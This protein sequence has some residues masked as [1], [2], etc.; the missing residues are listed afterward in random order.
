[1]LFITYTIIIVL[2]LILVILKLVKIY[3]SFMISLDFNVLVFFYLYLV[4]NGIPI[5]F[6]NESIL[7]YLCKHKFNLKLNANDLMNIFTDNID[8]KYNDKLEAI[9][10]NEDNVINKLILMFRKLPL[11][12]ANEDN[13]FIDNFFLSI[14]N[15]DDTDKLMIIDFKTNLKADF[16][17]YLII[18][19]SILNLLLL[20][21]YF[22][23]VIF[24]IYIIINI[25]VIINILKKS[26]IKTIE[27]CI[28]L[29]NW[30]ANLVAPLLILI[31][32][33]EQFTYNIYITFELIF[34]LI[35][36]LMGFVILSKDLVYSK[37]SKNNNFI[38]Y[39]DKIYVNILNNYRIVFF[40]S[41]FIMLILSNIYAFA[42]MLYQNNQAELLFNEFLLNSAMNY[43]T[44]TNDLLYLGNYYQNR[45]IFLYESIISFVNN[46][47]L[48]S[49]MA[50][51]FMKTYRIKQKKS[52]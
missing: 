9:L 40:F 19:I 25:L 50:Q 30:I 29:L 48:L 41:L 20:F 5:N 17:N 14:F 12:K 10:V 44:N 39:L 51:Y 23:V 34:L 45:L 46:T 47:L 8:E 52:D 27:H 7:I 1:M 3:K 13:T 22:N 37:Y 18:I 35:I 6:V 31:I 28:Y 36:S 16:E 33:G 21:I 2:V 42:I 24:T 38:M 11:K 32:Y 26:S 43:F 4:M 49:N 15:D